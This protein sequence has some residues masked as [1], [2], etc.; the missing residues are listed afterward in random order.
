MSETD[1]AFLR[2]AELIAAMNRAADDL[3]ARGWT[4][5]FK[6]EPADAFSAPFSRKHSNVS[7]TIHRE[8]GP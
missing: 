1:P 5:D 6:L 2:M 3:R 4:I 7:A 8:V